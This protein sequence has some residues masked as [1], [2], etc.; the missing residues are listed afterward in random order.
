MAGKVVSTLELEAVGGRI[1]CSSPNAPGFMYTKTTS[2]LSIS[3]F[4]CTGHMYKRVVH[5]NI[6]V[7]TNACFRYILDKMYNAIS[8]PG[9]CS[10]AIS[11][12]HPW[13]VI[14]RCSIVILHTFSNCPSHHVV[15]HNRSSLIAELTKQI[16]EC[17]WH[18]AVAVGKE[19][20]AGN[21]GTL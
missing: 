2:H 3:S 10:L 17:I 11:L 15:M 9:V 6:W 4:S 5:Q 20:F 12:I 13:R 19:S 8:S 21:P 14:L 18:D 16:E 7:Y 1:F